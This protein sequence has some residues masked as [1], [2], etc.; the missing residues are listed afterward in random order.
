MNATDIMQKPLSPASPSPSQS[1]MIRF[2]HS[3]EHCSG[4][5]PVCDH[6]SRRNIPCI[7][8][9]QAKNPRRSNTAAQQSSPSFGLKASYKK[10]YPNTSIQPISIPAANSFNQLNSSYL[11]P[12]QLNDVRHASAPLH[13]A[14]PLMS[15]GS[16]SMAG[17]NDLQ[18]N[19]QTGGLQLRP[20]SAIPPHLSSHSSLAS[21]FNSNSNSNMMQ[22]SPFSTSF[23]CSLPSDMGSST[24]GCSDTAGSFSSIG[25][26]YNQN[27]SINNAAAAAAYDLW[28]CQGLGFENTPDISISGMFTPEA[29]AT[30]NSAVA[31]NSADMMSTGFSGADASMQPPYRLVSPQDIHMQTAAAP[32]TAPAK[33]L[34]FGAHDAAASGLTS[35]QSPAPTKSQHK[36]SMT[37]E[38]AN[39]ISNIPLIEQSAIEESINFSADPSSLFGLYTQQPMSFSMPSFSAA[40]SIAMTSGMGSSDNNNSNPLLKSDETAAYMDFLV[41]YGISS[42]S[43]M[44]GQQQTQPMHSKQNSSGQKVAPELTVYQNSPESKSTTGKSNS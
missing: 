30:A 12:V 17:P 7:Y 15:A 31:S 34:S 28:N 20:A 22:L 9:P 40:S 19:S 16:G 43:Q 33:S 38:S 10:R 27:E 6:C 44:H 23:G 14:S 4:T 2:R 11:Q 25:S 26:F 29:A 3:C 18:Q 13:A 5:R 21:S 39:S 41:S 37:N 35:S 36:R 42:P 32:Q 24:P 8:K 1:P